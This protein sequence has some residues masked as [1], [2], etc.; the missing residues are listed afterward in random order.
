MPLTDSFTLVILPSALLN[1]LFSIP[2]FWL[3][4]DLSRWVNPVEEEE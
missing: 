1:L 2:V 4:R 3:T